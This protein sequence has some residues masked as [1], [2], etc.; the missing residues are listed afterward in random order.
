MNPILKTLGNNLSESKQN[1]FGVKKRKQRINL[2]D[3]GIIGGRW[4]A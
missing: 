1:K 3:N 2:S 4:N